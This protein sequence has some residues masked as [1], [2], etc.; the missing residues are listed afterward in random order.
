MNCVNYQIEVLPEAYDSLQNVR[1]LILF[2]MLMFCCVVN[3]DSRK[4]ITY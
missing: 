2:S 1:M 3:G 4:Y